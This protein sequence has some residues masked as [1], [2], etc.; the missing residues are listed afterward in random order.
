MADMIHIQV[1]YATPKEQ[2]LRDLAVAT[3]TN[4]QQAV[5][6]SGILHDFPEIDLTINRVG[7]FGK[8]K[9]L[10]ASLKEHDRIE[11][12]RPLIAEPKEARRRRVAKS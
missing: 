4:L 7:I 2:A 12:Y 9:T 5:M 3:G 6:Q 1:C 11:I 10:N 8:L